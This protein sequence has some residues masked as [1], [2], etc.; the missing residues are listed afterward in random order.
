LAS[1]LDKQ[2]CEHKEHDGEKP[3]KILDSKEIT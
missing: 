1:E 2:L 3:G